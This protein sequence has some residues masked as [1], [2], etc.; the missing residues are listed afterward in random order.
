MPNVAGHRDCNET[1][2]PGD[3]L[4]AFMNEVRQ[5]I[6]SRLAMQP[7]PTIEVRQSSTNNDLTFVWTGAEGS[8]Y[9]YFL[10]GWSAQGK[11]INYLAGFTPNLNAA[12]SD[13]TTS[14]SVSY[15]SLRQGHWKL[16]VRARNERGLTYK[17]TRSVLIA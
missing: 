14:N 9:S 6:A 1:S 15:S 8:E 10:Q 7:A 3:N 13:W 11:T 4:Y 5:R 17:A 16:H 12:W 2:C